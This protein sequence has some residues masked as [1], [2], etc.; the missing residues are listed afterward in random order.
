MTTYDK[1]IANMTAVIQQLNNISKSSLLGRLV[2]AV[3]IVIDLIILE[4]NRSSVIIT[5]VARSQRILNKQYYINKSLAF[6]LGATLE[7]DPITGEPKYG[8]VDP[9]AQIVKQVAI[10]QEI[11]T[12]IVI[13]VAKQIDGQN[14]ALAQDEL[15]D[16][17]TYLVNYFPLG[18]SFNISTGDPD[19]LNATKVYVYYDRAYS[20]TTIKQQISKSLNSLQIALRGDD[21]LFQ[22]DIESLLKQISGI[23]DAYFDSIVV[24]GSITPVN[25]L[26]ALP[27]GYFNFDASLQDIESG[28]YEFVAI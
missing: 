10:K 19:I 2:N 15:A 7:I 26:I 4:I 3:A 22:N 18:I 6:Q 28:K 9:A 5:E 20:L 27:S 13:K 16:F 1:I 23:R 21:P 24:N 12:G 14:A 25:G 11:G 8:T 17:E